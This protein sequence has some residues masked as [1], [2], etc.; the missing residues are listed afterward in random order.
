MRKQVNR[1]A[2]DPQNQWPSEKRPERLRI[3]DFDPEAEKRQLVVVTQFSGVWQQRDELRK[4]GRLVDQVRRGSAV[5]FLGVPSEGPPPF[6]HR[7]LNIIFNF[8]CLTVEAVLGFFLRQERE[9]NGWGIYSGPYAWSAGNSRSGS[10]VTRHPVFEG[11]PGPGLM[12]WEYG[13]VVTGG[14]VMP[15]RMSMEDAGPDLPMLSLK[16]G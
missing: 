1:R 15:A 7:S 10:P 13:N 2:A 12:D 5:L 4:F 8:S 9:N 16:N 3:R 6:Q 14:T 11:L